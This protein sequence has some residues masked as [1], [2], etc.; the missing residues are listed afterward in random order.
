MGVLMTGGGGRG[1][2]GLRAG[3]GGVVAIANGAALGGCIA[4]GCA[5]TFG[6]GGGCAVQLEAAANADARARGMAAKRRCS[7]AANLFEDDTQLAG[8]ATWNVD[9]GRKFQL[10]T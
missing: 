9:E 10:P 3:G 7:I 2:D 8:R 6:G 5:T 1:G 4:T